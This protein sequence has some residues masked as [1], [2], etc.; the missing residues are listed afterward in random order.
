MTYGFNEDKS[1]AEVYKVGQLS[2]LFKVV[3]YS[4]TMTDPGDGK[5]NYQFIGS[6][7]I[8]DGYSPIGAVIDT[9]AY[10]KSPICSISKKGTNPNYVRISTMCYANSSASYSSWAVKVYVYFVKNGFITTVS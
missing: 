8:P 5:L 7:K 10:D 9:L 3:E 2:D 1:K 4:T 6:V